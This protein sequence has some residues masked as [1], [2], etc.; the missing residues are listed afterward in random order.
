MLAIFSLQF[1]S[2]T[3]SVPS[4]KFSGIYYEP[5]LLNTAFDFEVLE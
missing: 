1:F 2:T 5:L 3:D 4:A